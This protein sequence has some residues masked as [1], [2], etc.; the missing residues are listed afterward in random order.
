MVIRKIF[1]IC[2]ITLSLPIFAQESFPQPYAERADVIAYIAELTEQH[3]FSEQELML[4]FARAHHRQD[5]ID[6]ISRP[7]EKTWTWARYRKLLVDEARIDKG[8]AFWADH[9]ETLARA[10]QV[11][12][13]EPEYVLAIL[14]IET[15][16]GEVKGSFAVLDALATLGF[17]YPPRAAFFRS[18]LTQFLL[19]AREEGKDPGQLLGS[20][21]GAMG[22]GQFISSSYRHY[23]VDFDDDGVRDIWA[24]PVDA[25]GSIANYFAEHNWREG[26]PVARELNL[27]AAQAQPWLTT[28]LKLPHTVAQ[29]AAADLAVGDLP[30][31]AKVALYRMDAQEQ[32]E[33]WLAL[34]NFYVITRYNRSH[35]YALAVHQLS[36][37]I[38]RRYNLLEMQ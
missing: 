35:M 10:Q 22:Y 37:E 3:G 1:F 11:F 25:I 38:K 13:V 4:L 9:A 21:A 8:V 31:E 19:L 32:D 17:D 18:E 33:Y 5:I 26:Q 29:L 28:G 36:Q 27:S 6:R 34:H 2:F 23:A 16:Y 30:A 7:A 15:R 24:N 20:Y 14:G 12:G